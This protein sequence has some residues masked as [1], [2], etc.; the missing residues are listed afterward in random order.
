MNVWEVLKT[1]PSLERANVFCL[2]PCKHNFNTTPSTKDV[3]AAKLWG[4]HHPL[5]GIFQ[6]VGKLTLT[7]THDRLVFFTEFIIEPLH[8]FVNIH[9][10]MLTHIFEKKKDALP[11]S[12]DQQDS[13]HWCGQQKKTD[14][15]SQEGE[16]QQGKC[17]R[18]WQN[19]Q[20]EICAQTLWATERQRKAKSGDWRVATF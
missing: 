1:K 18:H 8:T 20:P 16:G 2:G 6:L 9:V 19:D 15:A 13:Q 5:R 4:E 3:S 7:P 10:G 12:I 17:Q 14:N 11:L